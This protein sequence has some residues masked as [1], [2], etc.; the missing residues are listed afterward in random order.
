ME[1]VRASENEGARKM[2]ENG[3]QTAVEH[4]RVPG[5]TLRVGVTDRKT[6]SFFARE[7]KTTEEEKKE[8]KEGRTASR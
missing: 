8:E 5:T 1:K 2:I 7:Q 4:R 3:V 6:H